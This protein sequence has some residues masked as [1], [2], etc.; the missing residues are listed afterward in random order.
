M[1][2]VSVGYQR[3]FKYSDDEEL[4]VQVELGVRHTNPKGAGGCPFW[5]AR[6]AVAYG[7]LLCICGFL[8]DHDN[9]LEDALQ[10]APQCPA[11]S[12]SVVYL[13]SSPVII[14]PH[15]QLQ[16]TTRVWP[17]QCLTT[18]LHR[19]AFPFRSANI[20]GRNKKREDP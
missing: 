19:H 10:L 9:E 8:V 20:H 14:L 1:K 5:V 16:L 6:P 17:K 13:A 15:A 11:I 4:Q 18:S 7:R 12:L 2:G 3:Q